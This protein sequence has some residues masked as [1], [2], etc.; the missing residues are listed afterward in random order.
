MARDVS[1]LCQLIGSED[2]GASA[3]STGVVTRRMSLPT[4]LE[5]GSSTPSAMEPPAWP[6]EKVLRQ[7]REC[8]LHSSAGAPRLLLILVAASF[9]SLSICIRGLYNLD[10][11]P[12]PSVLSLVRQVLTAF[13]F[14]PILFVG[15]RRSGSSGSR[16]NSGSKSDMG[17][18]GRTVEVTVEVEECRASKAAN[19]ARVSFPSGLWLAAL[20]LA[21]WNFW[22]R[23]FIN[24]GLMFTDATRA[25]FFEQFSVAVT[26]FLACA[27]GQVVTR[28]AWLS[29]MLALIG[30]MFL[31]ADGGRA[32]ASIVAA[33]LSGLNLGDLMCLVG[34]ACYSVLILRLGALSRQNL[35]SVPLQAAKTFILCFLY[36]AWVFLAWIFVKQRCPLWEL[37]PGW[38]APAAWGILVVSAIGPGALGDIWMAQ[39]SIHVSAATASVLLSTEPLF[40]A[41]L[42]SFVLGERLGGRGL[43]GA[44]LISSAAVI[45]G[46]FE[47]G[48]GKEEKT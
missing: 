6:W 13:V 23:S 4:A 11:P 19:L 10:G 26:P 25:A 12:T 22:S 18:D 27:S 31:G 16:G 43:M 38:A 24:A 33:L 36:A 1:D 41:T 9:G 34:A 28:A 7:L 37:W 29:C 47:G 15:Q 14:L 46:A 30:V 3:Q 45:A 2:C 42:A 35:S 48:D 32:D 17:G 44:G 8:K 39:A 40:A 21:V 5:Q 20:E